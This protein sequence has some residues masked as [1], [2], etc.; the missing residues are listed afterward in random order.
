ETKGFA[1][2]IPFKLIFGVLLSSASP[3]V[4]ARF[5]AIIPSPFIE[6]FLVGDV[7]TRFI[8]C[9]DKETKALTLQT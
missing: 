1:M 5:F 9:I 7:S 3:E 4:T 6:F 2:N 8:E